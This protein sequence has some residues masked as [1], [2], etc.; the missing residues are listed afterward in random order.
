M[1]INA[2]SFS[3]LKYVCYKITSGVKISLLHHYLLI[4]SQRIQM[5]FFNEPILLPEKRNE[6]KRNPNA[7]GS[8]RELLN[9][10]TFQ[11]HQSI[12]V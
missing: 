10:Q 3:S 5:I 1:E 12:L 11:I 8:T 4:P 2:P 7:L 9:P 6:G